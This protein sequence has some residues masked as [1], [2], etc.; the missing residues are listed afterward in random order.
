MQ[1]NRLNLI[2]PPNTPGTS[3]AAVKPD[4]LPSE[5]GH[6]GATS[7]NESPTP[8]RKA[9]ATQPIEPAPTTAIPSVGVT[10]ALGESEKTRASGVYTREGVV[11]GRASAAMDQTPAE[12]FV[13][14]AVSILRDFDIGKATS[15]GNTASYNKPDALQGSRFGSFKQAVAKLNVFA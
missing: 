11:A 13:A 5:P 14:S 8:G 6:A 2:F 7:A 3:G 12:Q 1:I 4:A 15:H 10:L 9:T